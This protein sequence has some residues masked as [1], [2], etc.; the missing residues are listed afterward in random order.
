MKEKIV[1]FWRGSGSGDERVRARRQ[2]GGSDMK[3]WYGG[4][5][6][7]VC[8]WYLESCDMYLACSDGACAWGMITR[9]DGLDCD[10]NF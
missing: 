2:D 10:V 6:G 1:P 3:S 8:D 7:F 4:E 9:E 5:Y